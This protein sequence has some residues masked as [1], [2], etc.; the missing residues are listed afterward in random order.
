LSRGAGWKY[1]DSGANLGT[2]WKATGYSD[3]SWSSGNA[4]L[5]YGGI[6][7]EATVTTISYGPSSTSKYI[8]YYFRKTFTCTKSGNE[9]YYEINALIDDGAV[10]YINGIEI[11]RLNMPTGTIT[12]TTLASAAGNEDSYQQFII[13]T[14]FI[15]SGSNLIAVEVHQNVATSSDIGFNI[16]IIARNTSVTSVSQI[17]FGSTDTPRN[18]LT[19][20]WRNPGTSDSIKWGYT[21]AC[22]SGKHAGT[23]KSNYTD[24]LFDFSFPALPKDTVIYYSMWDSYF[25]CWT[26]VKTFH[27]AKEKDADHY[28]FTALGDSRTNWDDWNAIS[29]AVRPSDFVLFLGDLIDAGGTSSYWDSWY[30]HGTNFFESNTVYYTI[31]NH[32]ISGDASAVNYRN[33]LVMPPNPGNE[34]YYSFSVGN[35]VFICLNSSDAG[36]TA[37]YNWLISTLESNK[38]KKWR[39]VFFHKPFYTSPAHAGEMDAYFPTW[40]KA[41][42]DYGVEVIFNGHT[43]NYQRTIPINRN[44]STNSGVSGYGHCPLN[45]RCQIVAGAAGAPGSGVGTG[46]FI[47]TSVDTLNY[48]NVTIAGDTLAFKTYDRNN[49][50]IDSF[51]I[52]KTLDL[53]I[54]ASATAICSGDSVTLNASGAETYIWDHG[55]GNGMPFAP[56]QTELYSVIGSNSDQCADTMS[57]QVAVNPIYS[58]IENHGICNGEIYNWHGNDY[59]TSGTYYANYPSK[60]GCDS[61]YTLYLTV[62]PSSK[63]IQVKLF[64]EGLYIGGGLM[65]ETN[66]FDPI[67]EI[68]PP[69]WNTGIADTVT[70]VLYDDT[71]TN[72]M[73]KYPGVYLHTDGNLTIPGIAPSLSNSYYITIFHRNSV[74]VTTATPRPCADCL[75]SYD[76][77]TASSQAYEIAGLGLEPQKS[78]LDGY[79][80]MYSG[81][82]NQDT[83]YPIDGYDLSILLD[84][85]VI[86][87]YGYLVTDLN[88]DGSVDGFDLSIMIDNI[89]I[90]PIF[91]NPTLRKKKTSVLNQ[92]H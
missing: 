75:I 42:D 21:N 46:W 28:T 85:I 41:F 26:P 61:T 74:P 40:W 73:A 6:N 5:G 37:Q 7:A 88:G 34:L 4:L 53:R 84:D 70:V 12:Y 87:P 44:I 71:Y 22:L 29:N 14:S 27:T 3:A 68:F 91:Q 52:F 79:Y 59:S 57:V 30:A 50:I 31:G 48:V 25:R 54:D 89:V 35:A 36:N 11:K 67:N 1:N 49:I 20:T 60:Y 77:T 2:A 86:G 13:P 72:L 66:D 92:S 82:L 39:F 24:N 23:M 33:Q 62:D 80:G 45:G 32:D 19:I 90:N 8:T 76:F 65:R 10:F 81:E 47:S 17:H 9:T 64:L 56:L 15:Q 69:K 78:L 55:V 51:N 38:D 18:G 83:D 16:D 43:H 58:F 63:T